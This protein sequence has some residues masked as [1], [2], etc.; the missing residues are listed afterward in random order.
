L[1]G[2]KCFGTNANHQNVFDGNLLNNAQDTAANCHIGYEFKDGFVGLISQV[3]WYMGDISNKEVFNAI[4]K[5]QGSIDGTTYT[6]LFTLDDNLHEGWNYHN[7]EA[8]SEPKF[9]FY[10]FSG[11][12]VG[13]CN[14]NE[15]KFTGVETVDSISPNKDCPVKLTV[16]G[17][18]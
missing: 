15:I 11:T 3:R 1:Q 18:E 17:V 9:R 2:G 13:S 4:T 6:D 7:W 8:A 14:I 12:V 16:A 5:F 10:R